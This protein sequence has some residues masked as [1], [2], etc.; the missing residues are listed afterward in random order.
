MMGMN[1]RVRE[2]IDTRLKE[3]GMTR[4][5]LA[6]AIGRTPQ[7]IT[8]ALNGGEGGGSVPPLWAAMLEALDLELSAAPKDGGRG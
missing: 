5:D 1:G 4:A 2:G 7:T 3:K 6:R 8:R